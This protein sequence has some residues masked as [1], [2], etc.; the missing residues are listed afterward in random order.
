M[1]R[2]LWLFGV[3]GGSPRPGAWGAPPPCLDPMVVLAWPVGLWFFWVGVYAGDGLLAPDDLAGGGAA[4]A[5]A[6]GEL[7]D[8]EQ[9]AAFL[10]VVGGAAEPGQGGGTVE[11]LADQGAFVEE[12]QLDR[13]A[14]RVPERVGDQLGGQQLGGVGQL[15]QAPF[16]E[17]GADQTAGA[18]DGGGV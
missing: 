2:C 15:A 13:A 4:G 5:P 3:L 10:V 11:D 17:L 1:V 9:A 8:D 16:V 12:A 14:G 7:A 18:A 6:V